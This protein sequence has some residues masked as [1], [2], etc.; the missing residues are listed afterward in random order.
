MGKIIQSTTEHFSGSKLVQ[1]FS[2]QQ[3]SQTERKINRVYGKLHTVDNDTN[4][5]N[6]TLPLTWF[7]EVNF[8]AVGNLEYKPNTPQTSPAAWVKTTNPE[9]N[10]YS[11]RLNRVESK[12]SDSKGYVGF[13]GEF[14]RLSK[15]LR[16]TNNL[17]PY[18]QVLAQVLWS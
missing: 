18:C 11:A 6:R 16:L 1:V 13:K 4:D 9:Y 15:Q 7:S 12:D 3:S 14:C 10:E 5:K 17:S 8:T 2:S